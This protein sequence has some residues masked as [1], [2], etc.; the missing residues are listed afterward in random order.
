MSPVI[1]LGLILMWAV[2]LVPMW[3]RRHDEVEESRSVDKFST[4]MSTLSGHDAR[5]TPRNVKT[6]SY[7]A[8]PARQREAYAARRQA[9]AD[10]LVH[11]SG[12]SAPEAIA[13]RRKRTMARRRRNLLVGLAV[14]VL[15][16]FVAALA[17]GGVVLWAVQVV[18]DLA[19][20]SYCM[21][22]RRLALRAAASRRRALAR[23]R[24][25]RELAELER[26]TSWD[27]PEP[28]WEEGITVH[29]GPV[30]SSVRTVAMP[31]SSSAAAVA[32][33]VFDQTEPWDEAESMFAT[34]VAEPLGRA[35]A[36]DSVFDQELFEAEPEPEP[37]PA[38]E[39]AAAAKPASR[40]RVELETE[41]EAALAREYS[42][43][44]AARAAAHAA[45]EVLA[46][47]GKP[48]EPVPVPKPTYAT[49]PAAPSRPIYESPRDRL[50]PPLEPASELQSDDDL[51]AILD[52]RWA[53]ND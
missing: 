40:P 38:A 24:D 13:A 8:G 6:S 32:D 50:L 49:K 36:R 39:V 18:L 26:E 11:V 23:R 17:V 34:A 14:T 27:R 3:L 15:V 4:A 21:H 5:P 44:R 33:E 7:G 9:P 37:E 43:E 28:G 20:L 42:S 2:V 47:G 19:A 53:V 10:V 48:W 45:A 41:E 1:I 31:R 25:T 35:A 52:R 29:G 46:V 30:P 12:A 51:E 16:T 22:L